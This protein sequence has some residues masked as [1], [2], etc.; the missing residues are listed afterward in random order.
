MQQKVRQLAQQLEEAARAPRPASP[1]G[2]APGGPG[3]WLRTLLP[4]DSWRG[5][6]A[7]RGFRV[8]ARLL[9]RAG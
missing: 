4:R 8:A 2:A 7:R 5:R 1:P 9:K 6:V 3:R